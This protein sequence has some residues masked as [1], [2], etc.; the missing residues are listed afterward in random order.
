MPD[1]AALLGV[2]ADF[3]RR[4][5]GPF[6][7]DVILRELTEASRRVLDVAGA[8]VAYRVDGR[9]EYVYAVPDR[10][11]RAE[12][13][14]ADLQEGPCQ[15]SRLSGSLVVVE[16]L[17][18]RTERW[19]RFVERT[20]EVGLHAAASVPLTARDD[21]WGALT[22]YRE[23]PGPFDPADLAAARVLADVACS[24]V[25]MAHDRDAVLAAQEQAAHAATHD[26][27]T[28]LPNRALLYDRLT[29]AVATAQRAGT[30]LAVLFLD[31]D[32][33]K[34]IND[35]H[36]HSVGDLVLA[37]VAVRLSATLRAGD[38]LARLGGDEFVVVCEGLHPGP[39]GS[40]AGDD[41]TAVVERVR[42]ALAEP[43]DVAGRTLGVSASVGV[44]TVGEGTG[45]AESLLR[46]ADHA[47]YEV[48]R[49]S[50]G[51]AG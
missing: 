37:E 22:L 3:A 26:P 23:G 10:V 44:A 51:R 17:A 5:T 48:K 11:E 24:Y 50:R 34:E 38:T 20:L 35:A 4:A 14:Q 31:L 43:L 7:V 6:D 8:G 29:H 41:L 12:R 27:L 21:V 46:A 39:A 32:G 13:A 19:P 40:V 18:T 1:Q 33:F 47:M 45:E 28:G 16:D 30:P 9:M 49:A 2:F 36:G 25:V 15:E 42:G